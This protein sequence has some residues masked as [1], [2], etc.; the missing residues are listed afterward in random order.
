MKA[1]VALLEEDVERL[2]DAF[3]FRGAD[4]AYDSIRQDVPASGRGRL[5][6]KARN[7]E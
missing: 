4:N 5:L 3:G 7:A 1:G 2:H 6:A